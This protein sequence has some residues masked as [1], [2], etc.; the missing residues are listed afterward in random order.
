VIFNDLD[1]VRHEGRLGLDWKRSPVARPEFLYSI[2]SFAPIERPFSVTVIGDFDPAKLKTGFKGLK[3][4]MKKGAGKSAIGSVCRQIAL[5]AA[6]YRGTINQNLISVEM[7][8]R[9]HVRCSYVPEGGTE[10]AILPDILGTQRSFTQ[11]TVH[12]ALTGDQIRLRLHRKVFRRT[13]T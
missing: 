5:Q 9:G 8:N 6:Q 11:T 12:T 4:L 10:E 7:D 3:R 2:G 13:A 1:A